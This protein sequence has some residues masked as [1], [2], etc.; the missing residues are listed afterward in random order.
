M[1]TLHL[2]KNCFLA[3]LALHSDKVR[4]VDFN[5]HF[6]KEKDAIISEFAQILDVVV[7]SLL[8]YTWC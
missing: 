2:Q 6:E 7:Y 3:N 8:Y 5:I 4:I 1:D